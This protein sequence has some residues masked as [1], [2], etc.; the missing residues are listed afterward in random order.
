M[1]FIHLRQRNN[2]AMRQRFFSF[3]FRWVLRIRDITRLL[4]EIPEPTL[5]EF[6]QLFTLMCSSEES[7]NLLDGLLHVVRSILEERVIACEHFSSTKYSVSLSALIE[8]VSVRNPAATAADCKCVKSCLTL[9]SRLESKR[10]SITDAMRLEAN[11]INRALTSVSSLLLAPTND[12]KQK[13]KQLEQFCTYLGLPNILLYP[14]TLGPTGKSLLLKVKMMDG[15]TK[16]VVVVGKREEMLSE[17]FKILRSLDLPQNNRHSNRTQYILSPYFK[18]A[19]GE[20]VV[21]GVRVEEGEGLGLRK[22]LFRLVSYQMQ[23]K[24]RTSKGAT[25]IIS[26]EEGA[27]AVK[28]RSEGKVVVEPGCMLSITADQQG[29]K[30]FQKNI[31]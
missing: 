9:A 21:N 4:T 15:M 14:E 30:K 11:I 18:S 27:S 20:K 29:T 28:I 26:A 24:Y 25:F 16:P 23:E 2:S 31:I 8:A 6:I 22:E 19:Y 13:L 10:K 1:S 3:S 12:Y 17:V 7:L 5:Q